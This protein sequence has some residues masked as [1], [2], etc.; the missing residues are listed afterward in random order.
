M[1]TSTKYKRDMFSTNVEYFC[2]FWFLIY[3]KIMR[4][5]PWKIG[6]YTRWASWWDPYSWVAA[7]PEDCHLCT[8]ISKRRIIMQATV[9][10]KR[11]EVWLSSSLLNIICRQIWSQSK[12]EYMNR[13]RIYQTILFFHQKTRYYFTFLSPIRKKIQNL[14]S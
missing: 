11:E 13:S 12:S 4:F 1:A 2:E 5:S 7:I 3:E 9:Y 14:P 8:E 6:K 10:S